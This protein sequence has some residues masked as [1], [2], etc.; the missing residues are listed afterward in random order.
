MYN[1]RY[2]LVPAATLNSNATKGRE[3]TG[4]F[5]SLAF[6]AAAAA[7]VRRR[8]GEALLGHDTSGAPAAPVF[9]ENGG[10]REGGREGTGG[11]DKKR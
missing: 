8:R 10:K 11:R 9:E 1:F 3:T 6:F 7:G 2:L 5:F 4:K